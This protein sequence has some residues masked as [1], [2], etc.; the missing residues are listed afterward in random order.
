MNQRVV[1]NIIDWDRF[2]IFLEDI[3]FDGE[4]NFNILKACKWIFS[5]SWSSLLRFLSFSRDLGRGLL[6]A[7]YKPVLYG[8]SSLLLLSLELFHVVLLTTGSSAF[9]LDS[10]CILTVRHVVK[11]LRVL[12]AFSAS[13]ANNS[14]Q[15]NEFFDFSMHLRWLL[16]ISTI[17]ARPCP[18]LLLIN[19]TVLTK[20]YR[21]IWIAALQG[22]KDKT[23][24]KLAHE[25][26]IDWL[27]RCWSITR[28]V[29]D[30]RSC[31][32]LLSAQHL[33]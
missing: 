30:H 32:R 6:S 2:W 4:L 1:W 3:N 27:K 25:V 12:K 23:L 16:A 19:D 13:R 8:L 10:G 11:D 20:Q 24:T 18:L 5:A 14:E 15:F 7:S 26:V 28:L 31:D 29:D 21:T 17:R 22:I 33:F 9:F